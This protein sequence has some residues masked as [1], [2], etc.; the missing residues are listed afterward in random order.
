MKK[1]ASMVGVGAMV[2]TFGVNSLWAQQQQT[3]PPSGTAP[4]VTEKEPSKDVEKSKTPVA[5]PRAK[6][7]KAAPASRSLAKDS[8]LS[9]RTGSEVKPEVT[10]PAKPSDMKP[11]GQVKPSDEKAKGNETMANSGTEVKTEKSSE[12]KATTEA[13]PSKDATTKP[14]DE[15][16]PEKTGDGKPAK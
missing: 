10:A 3:F 2:I 13:K 11:A 9:V 14:L 12:T 6:A 8:G 1:I 4:A 7:D 5:A 15:K 16:S